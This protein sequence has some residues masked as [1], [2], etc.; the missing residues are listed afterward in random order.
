MIEVKNLCFNYEKPVLNDISFCI[1][2]GSFCGIT[3][4]TGSGK[5]TLVRLIAGLLKPSNGSLDVDKKVGLVFQY[6]EDQ[7][8]EDTV[9]K[10]VMF[11][12]KNMGY[13]DNQAKEMAIKALTDM[14]L[15]EDYFNRSPLRLSG[16]EKRKVAIAGILAMR[17]D[18]LV[19]DEPTAGLDCDMK[20]TLFEIMH[21]LNK[22]GKTIIMV[23]HDIDDIVQYCNQVLLL[24]E[25]NLVA[26]GKPCS[27]FSKDDAIMPFVYKKAT[28]YGVEI[29]ENLRTVEDLADG[30][31][32][33]LATRKVINQDKQEG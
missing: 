16:G 9:L 1:E 20:K 19:L 3:G 2:D 33:L 32:K 18:I 22:Q 12:P 24:K 11:G 13:S 7:L 25:G 5:S 31:S 21:K 26:Q 29:T 17:P 30:L 8:F 28:E 10:D 23:S 27:V 15:G 14:C 4:K 6:P